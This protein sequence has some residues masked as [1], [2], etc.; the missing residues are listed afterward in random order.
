[1]E[2]LR[3][4]G[5][6]AVAVGGE[7]APDAEMIAH[8]TVPSGVATD[9]HAYLR[10]GGIANLRELARFLSDTVLLTGEGF[11]P[12]QA[13]PEYGVHEIAPRAGERPAPRPSGVAPTVAVV[14]YRAHELSGN[15]AFVDT[16][17]HAIEDAGGAP[18]PVFSG[19]L[20]GLTRD[21]HPGLFEILDR[22]DA[23]ITTVLAAGG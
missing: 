5:V 16:L 20:R 22:A 14:F 4:G 13:M 11:Q 8:S 19:S 17:C 2:R 12:P 15:T 23:V 10:E 9:A 21:S 3:A 1:L 18:L 6:P 7:A